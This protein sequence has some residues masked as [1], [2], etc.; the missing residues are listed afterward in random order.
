M[1]DGSQHAAPRNFFWGG[2]LIFSLFHSF[3]CLPIFQ[4]LLRLTFLKL[5]CFYDETNSSVCSSFAHSVHK[6]SVSATCL[7][8]KTPV[9]GVEGERKRK[10]CFATSGN[11]RSSRRSQPGWA[12]RDL[13]TQVNRSFIYSCIRQVYILS[14]CCVLGT[15]LSPGESE[16]EHE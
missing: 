12:N 4:P 5:V 16:S 1:Q 13:H 7:S 15:G 8:P 2:L 9:I 11:S 14:S 10:T 3:S 6:N